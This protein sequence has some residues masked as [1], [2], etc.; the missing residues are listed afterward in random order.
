MVASSFSHIEGR[1]DNKF[2]LF[3]RGAQNGFE[4]RGGGGCKRFRTRSFPIL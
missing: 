1:G 4:V 3:K 2:P